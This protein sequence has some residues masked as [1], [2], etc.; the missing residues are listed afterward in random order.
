MSQ[1]E[2]LEDGTNAKRAFPAD[3]ARKFGLC[4]LTLRYFRC[5]GAH[6]GGEVGNYCPEFS[7]PD[8]AHNVHAG[9][10]PATTVTGSQGSQL[11]EPGSIS[12]FGGNYRETLATRHQGRNAKITTTASQR[13]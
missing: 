6:R 9:G 13:P 10:G 1:D 8:G 12:D 2:D 11:S 7:L 3:K 4:D 5:R